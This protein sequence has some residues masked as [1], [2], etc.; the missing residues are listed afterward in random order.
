M[1]SIS[2]YRLSTLK[3]S[4]IVQFIFSITLFVNKHEIHLFTKC[5]HLDIT[6]VLQTANYPTDPLQNIP[7]NHTISVSTNIYLIQKT[8]PA[9]PNSRFWYLTTGHDILVHA[10]S[11]MYKLVKT[12]T[13]SIHNIPIIK[14]V[15]I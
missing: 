13:S 15:L 11:T 5:L 12:E 1:R 6:L 8:H 3:S 10:H 4:F 9:L 2:I 7:S 14:A